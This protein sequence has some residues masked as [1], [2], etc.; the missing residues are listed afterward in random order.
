MTR[1]IS[2]ANDGTPV[3][4]SLPGR[5]NADA[6]V[7]CGCDHNLEAVADSKIAAGTAR[8]EQMY[9]RNLGGCGNNS[10]NQGEQDPHSGP[11]RVHFNRAMF[12]AKRRLGISPPALKDVL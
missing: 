1:A 9:E 11:I 12:L 7:G 10:Q 5:S 4:A 8:I 2:R 6:L 3:C